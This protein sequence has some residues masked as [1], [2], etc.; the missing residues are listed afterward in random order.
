MRTYR[1][2]PILITVVCLASS[3]NAQNEEKVL[4]SLDDLFSD[5]YEAKSFGPAYWFSDGSGY[6]VVEKAE[7]GGDKEI[8]KYDPE[9]GERIILVPSYRLKHPGSTDQIDLEGLQWAANYSKILFFTNR[10]SYEWEG[11][12][13]EYWVLDLFLWTWNQIGEDLPTQSLQSAKFSPDG[14]SVSFI[15]DGDIYIEDLSCY[16]VT[17]LTKKCGERV[18]N[19]RIKGCNTSMISLRYNELRFGHD[20]YTWS[21][22]SKKIAYCQID[23][24]NVPDYYMINNTETLYPEII[25]F[26]Y[27]KVGQQLPGFRVGITDISTPATT[28]L[29]L[30]CDP[31]KDYLWQMQ[32]TPNEHELSLQVLNRRQDS[33]KIILADTEHYVTKIIYTEVDEAWV[34]PTDIHWI[35]GGEKLIF[36]SERDGWEHIYMYSHEGDELGCLTPGE[37]DV[38]IIQGIDKENGWLYYVASPDNPCQRHLWRVGLD[39]KGKSESVTPVGTRGTH[40]YQVSPD[41]KWAIEDYSDADTPSVY[42]LINLPDHREV[43]ILEDNSK[44]RE[45]LNQL[46]R[47]PREFF[48]VNIGNS[49]ELDAYC[50]KPPL[51]DPGK[52]YPLLFHVY[53]EPAG[54]T[55]LDVW[56]GRQYLWHLMLAQKGYIVMSVDNRG[57][58]SLRGRAWRKVIHGQLGILAPKDQAAAARE[59]IRQRPF[60]DTSKVG[61]YGHSGGG[62]MSLHMIFRFPDV[63]KVAMPSS[64]VSNQRYYHPSYQERFMGPLDENIEA[65][66]LGSPITWAHQ[67]EGNLLI[68]H[69]TGDSNVHYQS[70][71][72]LINELVANKKQFSMMSY[73]NRN[74]GLQE[75]ENTQYHLYNLRTNYLKTHMTPD[76]Q[77]Y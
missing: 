4:L 53:G 13:G 52:K 44:L 54:Q 73:P 40:K 70:F 71:E 5:E 51:I 14:M 10:K 37:F 20:G 18:Y 38:V 67:L 32:W 69:G 72:A 50:I 76:N 12:T 27:I 56:G 26:P 7:S 75:G 31:F 22:D 43:K 3:V 45:K 48:R 46:N 19:G 66:R 35:D 62:Q 15:H 25:K 23:Y 9:T 28:W 65:Y 74:H 21:P 61:V 57:T 47:V 34:V 41:F 42:R 49:V 16:K 59:I 68:I 55:V 17:R 60:I 30:P 39:L 29:D 58:P 6:V 63:Y 33:M 8:V 36:M 1:L 11:D 24:T 77:Q 64:F 2:I